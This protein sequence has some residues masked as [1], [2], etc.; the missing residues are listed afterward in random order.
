[1][2]SSPPRDKPFAGRVAVVTGAGSG[3]GRAVALAFASRGAR[4]F[5]V[6]RTRATL[7]AV[8]TEAGRSGS[9]PAAVLV[10]DISDVDDVAR[11]AARILG[12]ASEIDFLIHSAGTISLGATEETSTDDFDRQYR[13]NVRGAFHLTRLLLPSLRGRHGHVAFVNSSAGLTA[14][15]GVGAYAASKHALRAVADSLREEV[16]ADG[17][18]VISVFLGRT[19]TPMQEAVHAAEGKSYRPELLLQPEDVAV[20]LITAMS[21]PATAEVTEIHIRPAIKSY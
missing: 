9:E 7:D 5:L 11:L 2:E 6:G 13:T 8:A 10:A 3:V 12:E 4:L 15:A 20:T 19:A 14:R 1:M 17:V 21:L 16:N 18:R